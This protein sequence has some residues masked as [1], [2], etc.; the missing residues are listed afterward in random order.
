MQE[1]ETKGTSK[2]TTMYA[3]WSTLD[4]PL[5]TKINHRIENNDEGSFLLKHLRLIPNQSVEMPTSLLRMFMSFYNSIENVSY[6][7][8]CGQN[9]NVT[10]E[11]VFFFTHLPITGRSIVTINSKDLQVFDRIFSIKKK[12]KNLA[13]SS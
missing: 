7:W 8:V 10:L 3:L 5:K 4:E 2:L 13:Y 1:M 11:Y 6:F 12:K 9:M